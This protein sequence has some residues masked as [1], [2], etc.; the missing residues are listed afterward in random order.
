MF[1]PLNGKNILIL[2]E[3]HVL[4]RITK[5]RPWDGRQTIGVS[6]FGTDRALTPPDL[7]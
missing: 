2:K 7:R 4:T 6:T 5:Y 3:Q 1:F